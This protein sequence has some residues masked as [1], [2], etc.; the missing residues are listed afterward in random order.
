MRPHIWALKEVDP[1]GL[2]RK[3]EFF[4]IASHKQKS[5][6]KTFG[7]KIGQWGPMLKYT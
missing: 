4:L 1:I 5:I 7:R 6:V 2:H 3:F